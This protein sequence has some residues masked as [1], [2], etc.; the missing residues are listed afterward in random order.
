MIEKIHKLISGLHFYGYI[1]KIRSVI[2]LNYET[3]YFFNSDQS[4]P[5][6]GGS[7]RWQCV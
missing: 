6:D 5:D 4:D 1:K 3:S 7:S 2:P